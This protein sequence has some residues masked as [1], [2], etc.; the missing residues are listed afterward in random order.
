M[1]EQ[2]RVFKLLDAV[3]LAKSDLEGT[4]R[5]M[6]LIIYADKEYTDGVPLTL[7]RILCM[8]LSACG[9]GQLFDFAD[10]HR[11]WRA[12]ADG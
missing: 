6:S 4:V 11:A 5:V 3:S 2:S 10:E 9:A 12:M 8:R 7:E 1:A